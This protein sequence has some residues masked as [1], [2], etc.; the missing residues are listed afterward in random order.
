MGRAVDIAAIDGQPVGP[1]HAGAR[2]LA[3]ALAEL[4]P[5]IRPTEIGSPWALVGPAYFTDADHQDHLHVGYDDPPEEGLK[6]PVDDGGEAPGEEVDDG[7]E[8]S[9]GR[10]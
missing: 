9:R 10:R 2:K 3:E 4:D 7:E 5:S 1:G 6:L 8:R